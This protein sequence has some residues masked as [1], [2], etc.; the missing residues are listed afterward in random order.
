MALVEKV[1]IFGDIEGIDAGRIGTFIEATGHLYGGSYPSRQE[2][3]SDEDLV[4]RTDTLLTG[5]GIL[6]PYPVTLCNSVEERAA[7]ILQACSL[8]RLENG[9]GLYWIID[10]N[11]AFLVE[12][13]KSL[14]DET[15]LQ[16]DILRSTT[17]IH[18]G[19]THIFDYSDKITG[20]RVVTFPP[21]PYRFP[22]H[23]TPAS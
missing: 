20:I 10:R 18:L 4:R 3:L 11:P 6:N 12:A 19:S 1:N 23:P 21:T 17:L 13:I 8:R 22:T 7:K 15:D 14:R 16:S 5:V 2:C 9:E